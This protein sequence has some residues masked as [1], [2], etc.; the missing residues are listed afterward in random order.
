MFEYLIAPKCGRNG[1]G[2]WRRQTGGRSGRM[3]WETEREILKAY[4]YTNVFVCDA[5]STSYVS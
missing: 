2:V 5:A 3:E 4:Y 1:G